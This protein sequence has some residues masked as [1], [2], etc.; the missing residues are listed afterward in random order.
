MCPCILDIKYCDNIWVSCVGTKQNVKL[1]QKYIIIYILFLM[2]LIEQLHL[3][4]YKCTY[5]ML[6][7]SIKNS[8]FDE[9]DKIFSH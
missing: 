4:Y 6:K 9:A 3:D 7:V 1:I 2:Q 8:G 5:K